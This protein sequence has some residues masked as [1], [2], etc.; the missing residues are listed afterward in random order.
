[1]IWFLQKGRSEE[2]R[3]PPR[4]FSNSDLD[5]RCYRRFGPRSH[6]NGHN[7]VD[8]LLF[9]FIGNLFRF[10]FDT[11]VREPHLVNFMCFDSRNGSTAF[12]ESFYG[13][14]FARESTFRTVCKFITVFQLTTHFVDNVRNHI[15][16]KYL[17]SVNLRAVLRGY[18]RTYVIRSP[19]RLIGVRPT[20]FC[21]FLFGRF[22]IF[23]V[24]IV[25]IHGLDGQRFKTRPQ[26]LSLNEMFL[27]ANTYEPGSREFSDLFETAVRMFPEDPTA[28]LNAAIAALGRKDYVSADRY[29]KNIRN[30]MQIPEYD[31]AIGV[32]IMMRDADYDRAEQ[33]FVVA[34]Q[35]GLEA[36]KENLEELA[37]IRE[38]LDRI[39]EAEM[40]K[41]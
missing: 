10:D 6:R 27:V 30:R 35:T 32:L 4:S 19:C 8:L 2:G 7:Q 12:L 28:N 17:I 31:N 33:C 38:N 18:V 14:I 20:A 41:H 36:A 39:R 16:G 40:K 15:A 9:G 34:A 11:A 5:F 13:N 29:L 26:N 37:R 1:M 24:E 3:S 21:N 22:T 25:D 23:F